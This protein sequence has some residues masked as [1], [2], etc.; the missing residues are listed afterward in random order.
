[1]GQAAGGT[2]F[3][4][5]MPFSLLFNVMAVRMIGEMMILILKM[6]FRMILKMIKMYVAMVILLK[7]VMDNS[8]RRLQRMVE[9]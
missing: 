8:T 2:D 1:M 4:T 7:I 3:D 5:K 9:G 6:V